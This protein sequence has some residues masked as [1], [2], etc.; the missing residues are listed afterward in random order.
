[1]GL[2]VEAAA[3]KGE[4]EELKLAI[5]DLEIKVGERKNSQ[6]NTQFEIWF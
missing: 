3:A 4:V 2:R 1:M 6:M 5:A